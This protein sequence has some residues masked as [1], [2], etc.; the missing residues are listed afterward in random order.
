M[1]RRCLAEW[2]RIPRVSRDNDDRQASSSPHLN[3]FPA[4]SGMIPWLDV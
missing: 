3:V 2:R 4:R 1:Q